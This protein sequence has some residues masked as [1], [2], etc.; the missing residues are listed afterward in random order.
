MMKPP[1]PHPPGGKKTAP[2]NAPHWG[3]GTQRMCDSGTDGSASF[4]FNYQKKSNLRIICTPRPPEADIRRQSLAPH[5]IEKKTLDARKK[6][7]RKKERKRK[8]SIIASF[9]VDNWG[10]GSQR[11]LHTYVS[12]SFLSFRIGYP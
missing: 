8:G 2:R 11:C 10:G 5:L 1:F 6:K 9:T 4:F 3:G 12:C 7:K